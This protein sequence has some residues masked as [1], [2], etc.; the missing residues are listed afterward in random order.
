MLEVRRRLRQRSEHLTLKGTSFREATASLSHTQNKLYYI[1]MRHYFYPLLAIAAVLFVGVFVT[2]IYSLYDIRHFDKLMHFSG[3]IAAAWFLAVWLGHGLTGLGKLKS[4]V[5]IMGCVALIGVVWEFAEFLANHLAADFPIFT[6]FF[7]GGDL[8][9][10][11]SDIAMDI[12]GAFLFYFS[13]SHR[14]IN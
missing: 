9:D 6:R 5:V 14:K 4:F 11:L 13:Y 1:F 3:G 7:Y 8:K 2:T 10:T 12:T